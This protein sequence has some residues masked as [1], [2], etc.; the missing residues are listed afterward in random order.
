VK[1]VLL[2]KLDP[3]ERL[4]Q[5]ERQVLLV[6]LDPQERLEQ[7]VKQVQQERKV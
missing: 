4:E 6:K 1:L 5:Q 2:V 3:Q 7:R